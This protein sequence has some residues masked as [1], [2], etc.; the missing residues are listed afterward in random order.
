[1]PENKLSE[2]VT[3]KI[4]IPKKN[5]GKHIDF[6]LSNIRLEDAGMKFENLH[7]YI[8]KSVKAMTE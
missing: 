7:C 6:W 4:K 1:M 8:I 3:D 5:A 2:G